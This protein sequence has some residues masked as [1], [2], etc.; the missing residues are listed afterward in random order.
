M[1][2]SEVDVMT[3]LPRPISCQETR[4]RR[5]GEYTRNYVLRWVHKLRV[6]SKKS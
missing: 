4:A 3:N 5:V 1:K 2:G 6:D